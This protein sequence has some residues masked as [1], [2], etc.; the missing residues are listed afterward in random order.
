MQLP[1]VAKDGGAHLVQISAEPMHSIHPE[2]QTTHQ[3]ASLVITIESLR[4]QVPVL[5]AVPIGR[6][7]L[8]SHVWTHFPSCRRYPSAHAEHRRLAK[9][10]IDV[11]DG[12]EH[13]EQPTG[14]A[15]GQSLTIHMDRFTHHH[16]DPCHCYP[17]TPLE[18]W[19]ESYRKP[20]SRRPLR[21]V[22]SG[23][24]AGPSKSDIDWRW[25][26]GS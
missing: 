3:Y 19:Q 23:S 24:S 4:W 17:Q 15:T 6:N 26:H 20:P 21:T 22:H 1:P 18:P 7:Q 25:V 8:A 11:K 2:E 16:T 13:S 12:M 10:V 9:G 14:Q 5:S